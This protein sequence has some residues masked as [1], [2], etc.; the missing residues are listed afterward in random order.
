MT[1]HSKIIAAVCCLV[2]ISAVLVVYLA[3]IGNIEN[4]AAALKFI[5]ISEAEEPET[6][7]VVPR[8]QAR[9]QVVSTARRDLISAVNRSRDLLRQKNELYRKQKTQLIHRID[10]YDKLR[11]EY[12]R[13]NAEHEDLKRQFDFFWRDAD[14]ELM[15]FGELLGQDVYL[16][17]NV[18]VVP[19]VASP[20]PT[21][22]N[23][24]TVEKSPT[25]VAV[26]ELQ[27]EQSQ[28]KLS[29]LEFSFNRTSHLIDAASVV[30]LETG[31][32]AVPTLIELLDDRE[33]IDV[34]FWA[35]GLLGSMGPAA[36]EAIDPLNELLID[37]NAEL[38]RAAAAAMTQI[39]QGR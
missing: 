10:D 21:D 14:S 22:D 9:H 4:R 35:C 34:R 17:N 16:S 38:A 26:L 13:L 28:S 5:D 7:I 6:L 37:Q 12:K 1:F 33:P 18:D 36:A 24:P 30:L 2:L 23:S 39:N 25:E 29:E 31:S 3:N 20:D 8:L 32:A 11:D 19:G 15:I 27:L